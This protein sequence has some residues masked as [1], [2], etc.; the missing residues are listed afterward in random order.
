VEVA[1]TYNT[2]ATI[3]VAKTDNTL[4]CYEQSMSIHYQ[5]TNVKITDESSKAQY[6][7]L[8]SLRINRCRANSPQ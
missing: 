7:G 8:T 6:S 2:A 3:S 1:K 4:I 5:N